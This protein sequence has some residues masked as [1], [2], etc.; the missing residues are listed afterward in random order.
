MLK[1]LPSFRRF[2]LHFDQLK[3][4][5]RQHTWVDIDMTSVIHPM[6]KLMSDWEQDSRLYERRARGSRESSR[7]ESQEVFECRRNTHTIHLPKKEGSPCGLSQ[8]SKVGCVGGKRLVA[9]CIGKKE[10]VAR[11]DSDRLVCLSWSGHQ[12]GVT[13]SVVY[14]VRCSYVWWLC[15][16]KIV[17][18]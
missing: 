14:P 6:I 13:F 8:S 1:S 9:R 5:A 4:H 16:P 3:D 12:L 11:R 10:L 15:W 2:Y 7:K 18:G 17:G